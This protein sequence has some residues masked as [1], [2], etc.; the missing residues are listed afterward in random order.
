MAKGSKSKRNDGRIRDMAELERISILGE[1]C[2]EI[3]QAIG[4]VMRHGW[5]AT[6]DMGPELEMQFNNRSDLERE[7][8]NLYAAVDMMAEAGDL[9]MAKI[10][11]ASIEHREKL[12]DFTYYQKDSRRKA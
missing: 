10:S 5:T 12:R 3:V 1:E 11:D 8:G 9:D 7:I 2:G 6:M 4:K